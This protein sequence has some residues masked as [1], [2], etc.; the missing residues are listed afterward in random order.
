MERGGAGR[1]VDGSEWFV[2]L[3]SLFLDFDRF[4]ALAVFFEAEGWEGVLYCTAGRGGEA[5]C[6]CVCVYGP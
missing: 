4:A 1:G 3:G 5:V 2:G 6:V